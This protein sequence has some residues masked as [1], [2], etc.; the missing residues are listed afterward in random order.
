MEHTQ[1]KKL[2][3]KKANVIIKLS[4]YKCEEDNY[5]GYADAYPADATFKT[6]GR[7][8]IFDC[9][10]IKSESS[11]NAETGADAKLI[12][13]AKLGKQL[14]VDVPNVYAIIA[15]RNEAEFSNRF[16]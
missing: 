6:Y 9:R 16:I 13:L 10:P 8:K 15:K 1:L 14:S 2:I 7:K 4:Q 12:V 3:E 5:E 11:F